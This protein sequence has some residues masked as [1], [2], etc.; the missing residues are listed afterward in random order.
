MQ[1]SLRRPRIESSSLV[2]I[3][4]KQSQVWDNR[5]AYRAYPPFAILE[6]KRARLCEAQAV[7][8]DCPAGH[9]QIYLNVLSPSV[10][11]WPDSLKRH[12]R[13]WE[14]LANDFL[15]APDGTWMDGARDAGAS[16]ANVNK[17]A[18]SFDPLGNEQQVDYS[19]LLLRRLLMQDLCF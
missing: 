11:I 13:Q 14:D 15:R 10:A 12:R 2:C 7:Y 9:S 1:Q 18:A 16:I 6:G 19:V 4:P 8:A 5:I 3:R 17:L